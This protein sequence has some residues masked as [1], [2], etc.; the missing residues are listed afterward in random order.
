NRGL[1]LLGHQRGDYAR[2]HPNEDVN[3]SQSTNDVY[4]TALKLACRTLVDRLLAASEVLQEGFAAKAAEFAD[5]LKIGR[6][7]LQDAVPM[8][9]GQEFGAYATIVRQARTRLAAA[10]EQL[11][12]INLGGTAIGTGVTAHP[13]YAARVCERL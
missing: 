8:T 10:A 4:P 1:E 3:L 7:Q 5:I 9:L 12:E 11:G 2:L 13:D 6:T